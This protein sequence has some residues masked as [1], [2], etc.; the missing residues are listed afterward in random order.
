MTPAITSPFRRSTRCELQ[1]VLNCVETAAGPGGAL[2][3]D[4]K[5]AGQPDRT[6]L[7]FG[8]G[9]WDQFLAAVR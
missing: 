7:S 2:V 3:R 5:E 8:A 9:A 4:T 6:V 1:G